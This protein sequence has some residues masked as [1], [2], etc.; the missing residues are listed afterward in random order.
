MVL[1]VDLNS[2]LLIA[3]IAFYTK[4]VLGYTGFVCFPSLRPPFDAQPIV[5]T[6]ATFKCKIGILGKPVRGFSRRKE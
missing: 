2:S 4:L 6:K 5:F 3:T 1:T